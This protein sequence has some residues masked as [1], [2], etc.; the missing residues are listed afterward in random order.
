[1]ARE[2]YRA[3]VKSDPTNINYLNNLARTYLRTGKYEQAR[4]V[5]LQALDLD[6]DS[7]ITNSNLGECLHFLGDYQGAMRYYKKAVEKGAREQDAFR[8]MK[9]LLFEQVPLAE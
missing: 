3:A 8:G 2:S 7:Q 9:R 1:M 5:L 6:P 4:D